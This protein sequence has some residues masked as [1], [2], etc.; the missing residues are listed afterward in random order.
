ML[1]L[2]SGCVQGA[3]SPSCLSKC[4]LGRPQAERAVVNPKQSSASINDNNNDIGKS[5]Q[6]RRRSWGGGGLGCV[7]ASGVSS[8]SRQV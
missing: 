6:I 4:Q 7:A 8:R 1:I 2:V 3:P 5:E